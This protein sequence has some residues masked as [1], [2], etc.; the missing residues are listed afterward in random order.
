[1][2]TYI[3]VPTSVDEIEQIHKLNYKT[4]V[5][6]IPQHEVRA[7]KSLIDKFHFKNNYL[8]AKKND[9]VVGMICY[10]TVRPFSLDK[11]LDNID[12]Y[13]PANSKIVEI[14]LFAVVESSRNGLIAFRLIKGLYKLLKDEGFDFGIISGTVRELE[15]Y[16]KIG[17]VQF[18]P[19][20][21]KKNAMYQPMYLTVENLRNDFKTDSD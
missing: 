16:H 19:P 18:G 5:E 6:E 9:E 20:V 21:G 15:F 13:F 1:M 10:N 4:F 14:R 3:K 7:N 11:K 8:I 17:F 12:K 2:K